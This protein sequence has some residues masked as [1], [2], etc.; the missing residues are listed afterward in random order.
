META[1]AT[2]EDKTLQLLLQYR[3]IDGMTWEQIAV[4]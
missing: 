2:V 4:K 3:Y 1:I